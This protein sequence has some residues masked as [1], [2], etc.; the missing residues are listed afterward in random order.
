MSNPTSSIWASFRLRLTYTRWV[1]GISLGRCSASMRARL[2]R[3]DAAAEEAAGRAE[4]VDI[5]RSMLARAAGFA[6]D[7]IWDLTGS[8]APRDATRRAKPVGSL[9]DET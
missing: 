4:A 8:H 9:R 6:R 2:F 1:R 7:L 5:G 3:F